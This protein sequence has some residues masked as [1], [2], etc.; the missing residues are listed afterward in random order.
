M[1]KAASPIRLQEELMQAAESTAKRFHR[2]TAEQIEYWADLG[3]KVATTLD[4]D[5]LLSVSSGLSIIKT[6]PVF[7]APIDPEFVFQALESERQSGEL[8]KKVTNNAI[9]YQASTKHPGT[10]EKIDPDGKITMGQFKNGQFIELTSI[11]F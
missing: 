4:P 6:E 10:L 8:R 11:D 1:V 5:I 2:S 9:K 7:S 3:R